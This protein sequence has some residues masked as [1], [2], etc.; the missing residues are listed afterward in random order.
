MLVRSDP[1][2]THVTAASLQT[3]L[4]II[5]LRSAGLH[6]QDVSLPAGSSVSSVTAGTFLDPSDAL[7]AQLPAGAVLNRCSP[8]PVGAVIYFC[9]FVL[10]C[11]LVLV[12]FVIG[13]IIDNFASSCQHDDLLVSMNNVDHFA[14]VPWCARRCLQQHSLVG[15]CHGPGG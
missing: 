13:V 5:A 10:L 14:K 2:I 3:F 12:N 6:V 9:T 4:D 8:S 15:S 7:L 1:N 11:G